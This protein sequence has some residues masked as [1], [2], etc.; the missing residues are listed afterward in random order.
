MDGFGISSNQFLNPLKTKK[1]N[2]VSLED[3]KFSKIGYYGD[4]ETVGK[5]MDLLHEFQDMF[6]RKFLEMKRVYQRSW[7]NENNFKA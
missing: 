2:I 4:E 7:R 6:L 1:V 5:I 3:P